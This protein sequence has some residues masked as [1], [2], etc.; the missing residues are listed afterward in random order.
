MVPGAPA[1]APTPLRGRAAT[2]VASIAH[3]WPAELL[4]HGAPVEFTWTYELDATPA[5][6][7]PYLCDTSRFNRALGMS[8]FNYAEVNGVLHGTSYNAG[9]L[10]EWTEAPWTWVAEQTMSITRTYL[11]GLAH[12]MRSTYELT[13]LDERTRTR[14]VITFGWIPRNLFS[15]YV[16]RLGF[17][18]IGKQYDRV[19]A[20]IIETIRGRSPESP[21]LQPAPPLSPEGRERLDRRRE[22]LRTQLTSGPECY[23]A[24]TGSPSTSLAATSSTSNGC[25]HSPSRV[26]GSSTG[27]TCSSAFSTRHAQGCWTSLGT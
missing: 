23:T 21:Y 12:Q 20:E 4:A 19:I 2:E 16:L 17:P 14:V 7:W 3:A 22:Q 6:L 5:E 11:R 25:S 27:V 15:R 1:Q 8:E 9:Q 10:Q 18:T 13:A 24:S 26:G